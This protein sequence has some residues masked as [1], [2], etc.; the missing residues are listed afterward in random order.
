MQI[1]SFPFLGCFAVLLAL[2]WFMPRK[3][4]WQNVLLLLASLGYLCSWG[5]ATP[6]VVLASTVLE[7]IV[8]RRLGATESVRGRLAL[9]WTSIAL[10]LG[11]VILF[12]YA[13]FLKMIVP[14]IPFVPQG[15]VFV[16]LLI[17]VGVSFWVLQKMTLTYDVY[18]RRKPAE[19]SLL[20]CILFTSFF[21]TLLSGPIERS[22]HFLPQLDRVRTWDTQRFSQGVWL[23]AIGIFQKV[24][25]AD[26]AGTVVDELYRPENHGGIAIYL[27]MIAYSVQL[28]GDFAGYSD[29]V[30][31]VSRLVGIEVTRNFAAPYLSQ[32]LSDFWKNW[33]VSF[34][35]WLN[36]FVFN[37]TLMA[38]RDFGAAAVIVATWITFLISGLWHGTGWN[39]V[40]Y[41]SLHALG[42]SVYALTRDRRKAFAK[43]HKNDR[44][45]T[46]LAIV[47]T[48]HWVCFTFL[49]FHARDLPQALSQVGE[50]FT[51]S[52]NPFGSSLSVTWGIFVATLLGVAGLHYLIR[53]HGEFWAF[54]AP[55]WVRVFV[56][57]ALGLLMLRFYA[58]SE[59]FLYFQF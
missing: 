28:F 39:F 38:V 34:S 17:P 10:N 35:S 44:W 47:A 40:V 16:H 22:R 57:L 43:L 11:T 45:P 3:A 7:W 13:M 2:H 59:R 6:I 18:Y 37:P 32:N 42:L 51:G 12:K 4:P 25:I 1:I 14:V 20:R 8:S 46:V 15:D 27:G 56:Y 24:V 54:K 48:F 30:R 53:S 52:W 21:P 31:G 19:P 58:P 55:V 26:N 36:D 9:L 33:H 50:L 5:W 23:I 41:G 29:M 49:F